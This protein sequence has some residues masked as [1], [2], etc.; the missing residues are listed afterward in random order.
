MELGRET[1]LE[2]NIVEETSFWLSTLSIL[3]AMQRYGKT[4][5]GGKLGA[6]PLGTLPPD[7]LVSGLSS[8]SVSPSASLIAFLKVDTDA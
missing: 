5:F 8:H 1:E 2:K 7:W 3:D 4:R 6:G